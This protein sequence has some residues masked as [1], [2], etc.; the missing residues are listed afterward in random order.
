[1]DADIAIIAAIIV[2]F[3]TAI[4]A[5]CYRYNPVI[6]FFMVTCMT[7]QTFARGVLH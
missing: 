4:E 3:E 5:Q 2:M 6:P 1:M 7:P